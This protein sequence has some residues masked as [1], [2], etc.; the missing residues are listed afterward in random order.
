LLAA[1]RENCLP[2]GIIRPRLSAELGIEIKALPGLDH[3]VD[4]ERANLP[5]QLHDVEGRRVDRN[6]HAK[7][8]A[9]AGGQQRRE[10]VAEIVLSDRLVNE[11]D[12]ARVEQLAV[13]V[14]RVDHHETLFV[15][16][17]VALDQGQS[18]LADRA[19]TNHH[20]GPVDAGMYWPF[21]H[22]QRLPG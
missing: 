10:Q 2:Q 20:D 13:L 18:A 5:A 6:V 19:E 12:A 8:L 22:L 1:R 17:E 11:A 9:A 7:A 21:G 4:V 3:G 15:I 16:S 14:L